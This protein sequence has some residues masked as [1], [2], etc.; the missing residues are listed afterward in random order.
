LTT[1][2]VLV[3]DRVLFFVF[4]LHFDFNTNMYVYYERIS[5]IW[6]KGQ[7]FL[8]VNIIFPLSTQWNRFLI[9]LTIFSKHRATSVINK[10][11]SKI[12][13]SY[14]KEISQNISQYLPDFGS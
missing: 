12:P 14:T 10:T 4:A 9:Q 5:C 7:L 3:K 2:H 6:Q 8:V 1:E 13:A 11:C